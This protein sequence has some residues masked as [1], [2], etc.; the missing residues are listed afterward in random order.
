[1]GYP[2]EE[3]GK[4]YSRHQDGICKDKKAR[5]IFEELTIFQC[6]TSKNHECRARK[7]K[8]HKVEGQ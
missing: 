8:G 6:V 4:E 5:G 2:G 3:K 1:M 7:V